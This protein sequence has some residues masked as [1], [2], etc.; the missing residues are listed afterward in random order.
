VSSNRVSIKITIKGL[1][2]ITALQDLATEGVARA[3]RDLDAALDRT[4]E[5]EPRR[6]PFRCRRAAPQKSHSS[7]TSTNDGPRA[8]SCTAAARPPSK[9]AMGGE[10]SADIDPLA[11]VSDP[12]LEAALVSASSICSECGRQKE[13]HLRDEPGT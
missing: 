3:Q 10:H 9:L 6:R 13:L 12:D 8:I 4:A 5:K 1:D 2:G 11:A 7:I